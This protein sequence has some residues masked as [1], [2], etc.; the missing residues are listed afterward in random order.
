MAS[1]SKTR[2]MGSAKTLG[3]TTRTDDDDDKMT[4]TELRSPRAD[5]QLQGMSDGVHLTLDKDD[6]IVGQSG[7]NGLM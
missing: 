4:L 2:I 6:W 1:L 5:C 7:A 3:Q